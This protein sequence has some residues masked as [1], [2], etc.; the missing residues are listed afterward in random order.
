MG[1]YG[2]LLKNC[3]VTWA[4][5]TAWQPGKLATSLFLDAVAGD[6]EYEAAVRAKAEVAPMTLYQLVQAA[7]DLVLALYSSE[8]PFGG[9]WVKAAETFIL[10]LLAQMPPVPAGVVHR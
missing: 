9:F 3:T 4:A 7:F 2:Q 5:N 10:E 6:P 1:P 8:L